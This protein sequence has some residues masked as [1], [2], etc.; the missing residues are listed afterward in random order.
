MALVKVYT[1]SEIM[2]TG[3]KSK[4]EE[5]G[6]NP[7]VKNNIKSAT[8]AGFPAIGQAMELYVEEHEVE[9]A[10]AVIA[11]FKKHTYAFYT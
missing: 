4:L 3:V 7:M 9:T 1:G 11:Q 8:L 5:A 10:N 6:I 2:A